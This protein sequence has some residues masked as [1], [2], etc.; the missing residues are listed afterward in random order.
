MVCFLEAFFTTILTKPQKLMDILF[1]NLIETWAVFQIKVIKYSVKDS[2]FTVSFSRALLPS[3]RTQETQVVISE[4][5]LVTKIICTYRRTLNISEAIAQ[6]KQAREEH[7]LSLNKLLL[8]RTMETRDLRAGR[9]VNSD[10]PIVWGF[11]AMNSAM[12]SSSTLLNVVS[13]HMMWGV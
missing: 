13:D 3:P 1:R 8:L 9:R 5:T 7:L 12:N 2:L 11:S 4:F 10:A 6:A